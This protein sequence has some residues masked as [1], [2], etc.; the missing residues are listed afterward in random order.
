M[1]FQSARVPERFQRC[2]CFEAF[3]RSYRARARTFSLVA[4]FLAQ[5]VRTL[6]IDNGLIQWKARELFFETFAH[7]IFILYVYFVDDSDFSRAVPLIYNLK[8]ARVHI[9]KLI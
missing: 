7:V 8:L 2:Y 1:L 4:N 5:F 6:N 9:K 3:V